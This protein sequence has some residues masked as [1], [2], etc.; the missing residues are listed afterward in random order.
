MNWISI[1][2]N[3]SSCILHIQNNENKNSQYKQTI[4]IIKINMN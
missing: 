1:K 4:N 2:L 3:I